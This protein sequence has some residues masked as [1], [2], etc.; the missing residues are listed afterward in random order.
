MKHAKNDD[1]QCGIEHFITCCFC[2]KKIN[3]IKVYGPEDLTISCRIK[4]EYPDD[5]YTAID[6]SFCLCETCF[7]TKFVP[8]LIEHGAAS[9]DSE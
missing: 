5:A 2:G 3:M 4:R 7:Y 8:W 1:S 6:D 9:T